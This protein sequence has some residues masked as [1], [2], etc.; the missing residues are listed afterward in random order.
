MK[1]TLTATLLHICSALYS[2]IAKAAP[3][4]ALPDDCPKIVSRDEWGARP[5]RN[6]TQRDPLAPYLIVHHGGFKKFCSTH[7]ECAKIVRYYQDFH[8]D[9]RGWDDIGYSYLIGEDGNIY[10]GRGWQRVGAHAPPYNNIS[11]G[12]CFIGDFSDRLPNETALAA[13]R[14]LI[15]CS[16][17]SNFLMNNYTML[18]HRQAKATLCPGD[19]LFKEISQWPHWKSTPAPT[20][21]RKV[22]DVISRPN[23][24]AYE[25][26][27]NILDFFKSLF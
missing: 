6:F 12:V 27:N 17:S 4:F 8:M 26:I 19:A 18:G 3:T 25:A 24:W 16:I 14:S 2:S 5:A 15:K 23:N 22:D 10:E 20:E 11:I 13:L 9:D 21:I 1:L 7:D